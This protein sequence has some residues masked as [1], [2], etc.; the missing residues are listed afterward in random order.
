M[1][2]PPECDDLIITYDPN[3]MSR[4]LYDQVTV[5]REQQVGKLVL[6]MYEKDRIVN[7]IQ[8]NCS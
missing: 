2:F 4:E 3:V 8:P 6:R 5:Y 7:R 1:I